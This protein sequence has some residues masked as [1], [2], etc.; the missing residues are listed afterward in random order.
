MDI[1][2]T[3]IE[4]L[5]VAA[6]FGQLGIVLA[7]LGV[8]RAL[9]WGKE[10][11]RL[12]PLNRQIFKVYAGYIFTTHIAFVLISLLGPQL[13]CDGSPLAAAVTGYMAVYWGARLLLQFV[14]FDRSDTPRGSIY[15]AAE[16]LFVI[17]FI[18]LTAV[19]GTCL[20]ANMTR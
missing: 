20:V 13:L 10:L 15:F 9:E 3:L 2:P 6:G 1:D 19:Y 17:I 12:R 18:G 5:V 16:V 8:P 14:F 7:S 4:R 11:T